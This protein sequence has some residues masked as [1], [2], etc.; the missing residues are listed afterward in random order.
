MM[1]STFVVELCVSP[2]SFKSG[3]VSLYY[4]PLLLSEYVCIIIFPIGLSYLFP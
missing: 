3:F 4:R 2:F 1:F